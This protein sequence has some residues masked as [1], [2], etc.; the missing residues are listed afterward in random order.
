M[1]DEYIYHDVMSDEVLDELL[2]IVDQIDVASPR[3]Y[4][5]A[6]LEHKK[7]PILYH[8]SPVRE[9]IINWYPIK[10]G[11]CVLEIGSQCG[12]VT[13]VFLKT[14]GRVVAIDTSEKACEINRKRHNNAAN[15]EVKTGD[16]KSI[17][18]SSDEKYDLIT[19]IGGVLPDE[20][21]LLFLKNYLKDSGNIIVS[22]DNRLGLRYLAGCQDDGIEKYT[23]KQLENL[24]ASAGFTQ[25]SFYYLQPNSV[26]PN[27]IYSDERLPKHG[28]LAE[29][30]RNFDRPRYVY[31]DE[32]QVY[33]SLAEEG[34]FP[35]FANSY[36]AVLGKQ[37]ER[38]VI[39]SKMA[40]ENRDY[41]LRIATSIVKTAEGLKVIKSNVL[42]DSREWLN[43]IRENEVKLERV[44]VDAADVVKATMTDEGLVYDY[45]DGI[46]ME[47]EFETASE[48]GSVDKIYQVL[49]R[50]Y[51]LIRCMKTDDAFVSSDSFRAVFGDVEIPENE[52]SG[53]VV[54]I[55]LI[56]PNIIISDGRYKILDCEWTFNF[57]IPLKYVFWRG[58]SYNSIFLGLSEGLKEEIL[59]HYK[60]TKTDID[61]YVKM[62]KSFMDNVV[63]GNAT[64]MFNYCQAIPFHINTVS[65]LESQNAA[66][67][68]ENAALQQEKA[69]LE[70]DINNITRSKSWR[71]LRFLRIVKR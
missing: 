38:K 42:P 29:N 16:Y 60:L 67:Q 28:E 20:E 30:I 2:E 45:I 52:E 46:G 59:E 44:F 56:F 15:L 43:T 12:A 48:E 41:R 19:L 64:R 69:I 68:Q 37:S 65:S 11:A 23:K 55:D 4:D 62:E 34:V 25:Y 21:S 8:L 9:S 24:F 3:V 36:L 26:F 57:P 63:Y 22:A 71:I 17:L 66:L 7:W 40:S 6:I 13:G 39:Y 33:D 31:W 61:Q 35:S 1:S 50:Y 53:T 47:S 51:S 5:K 58:V 18:L 32:S 27:V 14:A 49:D 70:N 10:N 54:D